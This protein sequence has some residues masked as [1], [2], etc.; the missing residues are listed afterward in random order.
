MFTNYTQSVNKVIMET[1]NEIKTN[2]NNSV[3]ILYKLTTF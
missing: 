3:T 1:K 2:E